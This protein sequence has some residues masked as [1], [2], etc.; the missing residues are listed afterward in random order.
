MTAKAHNFQAPPPGQGSGKICVDCGQRQAVVSVDEG[1]AECL[2]GNLPLPK[3]VQH[4]YNPH[5]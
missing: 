2:G 5:A 4:E 3:E 1:Q